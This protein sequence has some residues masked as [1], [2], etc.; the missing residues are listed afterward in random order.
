MGTG[1]ALIVSEGTEVGEEDGEEGGICVF[2]VVVNVVSSFESKTYKRSSLYDGGDD[3]A[4][5]NVNKQITENEMK[6]RTTK[7]RLKLFMIF[8][9]KMKKRN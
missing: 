4:P 7:M 3:E 5:N 2:A 1:A 6:E 9:S 8:F